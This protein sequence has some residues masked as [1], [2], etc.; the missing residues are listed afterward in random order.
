MEIKR[1]RLKADL[2]AVDVKLEE[3]ANK[4]DNAE[5]LCVQ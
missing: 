2:A 5:N 3:A 1:K 4:L